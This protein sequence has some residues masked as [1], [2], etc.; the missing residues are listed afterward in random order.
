MSQR[1]ILILDLADRSCP[2]DQHTSLS[3]LVRGCLAPDEVTIHVTR[4]LGGDHEV[5]TPDCV[6]L[7]PSHAM[8]V[9]SALPS[10]R[11]R[12]ADVPVLGLLCA[13][14]DDGHVS[15]A[16]T[17]G[18]DDFLLCP[19]RP[20]ELGPRMDRLLC[21]ESL[22]AETAGV[23]ALTSGRFQVH[24]L[25]GRA[26]CFVRQVAKIPL[27]AKVDATVLIAGETGTGKELFA[28]A[29]HYH[30]GR[31][32]KPFVPVNCGALPDQL[33]ENEIFGHVRGA[34]TNAFAHQRGLVAEAEGGTL[35]LDEIDTLSAAAQTKLLRFLQDRHYRPLGSPKPVVADVRIIAATNGDLRRHV[36]ARTFREDLY[37]RL[38]ILSLSI[39][40]LRDRLTDVP[41][42]VTHFVRHYGHQAGRRPMRIATDALQKLLLYGWPGNVR[43][44]EGIIQRA[45]VLSASALLDA[46]QLELPVPPPALPG[47]SEPSLRAAKASAVREFERG[48]LIRLLA[49]FQGNVT[50]AA[51]SAGKERRAFQRLLDKHGLDRQSFREHG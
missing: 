5:P 49:S 23:S 32:G 20:M 2:G 29:I 25:V 33:F 44:L 16:F 9:S 26:E 1:Q 35:F 17:T 4:A 48:Y 15:H 19:F 41:E 3:G 7:R 31:N 43:E 47:P 22:R 51:Q 40:P 30:S 45:V 28:R 21:R 12:W 37:Y 13:Q 18:L 46:E 10:V 14:Q 24:G 11:R 8:P 42:L 38:N 34:F 27:F 39:P 50:H 36:E 6:V